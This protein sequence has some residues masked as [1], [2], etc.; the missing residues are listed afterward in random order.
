M[1]LICPESQKILSL[2]QQPGLASVGA[3]PQQH[4]IT[5][6]FQVFSHRSAP[7]EYP[8]TA[9][10]VNEGDAFPMDL[11]AHIATVEVYNLSQESVPFN[12][13]QLF[14]RFC[15]MFARRSSIFFSFL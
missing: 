7:F 9:R 5:Q 15:S 14:L 6:R 11:E 8:E 4:F 1:Q 13:D 3:I 10:C 12:D 2:E